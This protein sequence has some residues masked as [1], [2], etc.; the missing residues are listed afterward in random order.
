MLLCQSGRTEDAKPYL[1]RLGYT[2]R[3]ASCVLNYPLSSEINDNPNLTDKS[4][5]QAQKN[6]AAP[7]CVWDNF[8]NQ[9]E[10]QHLQRVFQDSK[11]DYWVSH[12]YEVEPPSPYFSYI[13]PLE[14][15]KSGSSMKVDVRFG[16]LGDIIVELYEQ[17]LD[18]FPKLSGATAVEMW[19]HN[20]PHP[21]GHQFHFDSD[22]E[23]QGKIIKNPIISLTQFQK[24]KSDFPEVPNYELET[25]EI[26]LAAGWLIE[27]AG[28]KGYKEN[29][30]G[31]HEKQALVLVN[32]GAGTGQDILN[33]AK[34]I[35][36]SVQSKF[37]VNL[38]PEVNFI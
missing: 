23:G 13:I 18:Q 25:G 24:L 16:A 28:W 22:N 37:G 4:N 6:T 12:N 17:L 20:R 38:S 32:Y 3:L 7:C 31:V 26:K 8:L 19:G 5:S 9:S 11:A 35:Q 29:G 36:D 30:V 27:H 33:L 1:Q 2:C 14:R 21:S 34:K 10:L 15:D